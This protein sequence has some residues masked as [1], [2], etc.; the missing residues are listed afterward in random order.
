MDTWAGGGAFG[1]ATS[2]VIT[3]FDPVI[4]D[5]TQG[6]GMPFSNDNS[7]PWIPPTEIWQPEQPAPIADPYNEDPY[8]PDPY[9]RL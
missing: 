7:A 6:C 2:T 4:R 1:F 9:A 8:F 5:R 3:S